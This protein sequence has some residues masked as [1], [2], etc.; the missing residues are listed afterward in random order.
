MTPSVPLFPPIPLAEWAD[1]KDTLH[2]YAQIVGKIRLDQ[3]PGRNHW[4][5]VPFHLTGRG[6]TT[7]PMGV[8]PIFAIDFDLVDHR[9]EVCTISGDRV[10][11]ALP[12]LSVA[13][14]YDRLLAALASL[15][16]D[17]SIRP[18]PFDLADTTPF[19]EDTAHAS[20]DPFWVTR[21][22]QVL[23]QVAMVLEQ[24][25]GRTCGKTSPVHHFWHTFDLAVTR[26]SDRRVTHPPDVD[27]VTREAYS[28]EVISVGF[29]FGD[30]NVPE[31]AFYA[32][33]APEPDG[34]IEEPLRPREASWVESRGAHLALLRYEDARTTEDARATVL[35]FYESV[36]QAAATRAGWDL[37][38]LRWPQDSTSAVQEGSPREG[39]PPEGR[40]E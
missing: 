34:L 16:I 18:V 21:Y 22:W 20:Y 9:L 39:V 14:F 19:A 23:S 26:F 38:R 11:F 7:R 5:N 13:T 3:S 29:W 40:E 25:A 32:Y 30:N 37:D 1:T 28:H 8:D 15:G 36:Y 2:R 35:D 31:P 27:P 10:S 6:I 4:W 12:G 24:F 33:A 17:V